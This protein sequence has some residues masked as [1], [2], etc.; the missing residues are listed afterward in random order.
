MKYRQ[1]DINLNIGVGKPRKLTYHI[2]EEPAVNTFNEELAKEYAKHYRLVDKKVLEVKPL[3]EILNDYMPK[4]TD[5]DFMN[6]DVE[7]MDLEVLESNDW[8]KYRPK[9]IL[10]EVLNISSIEDIIKHEITMFLRKKGYAL[11][12]KSFNTCFFKER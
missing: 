7:G 11:F 12:A 5:I 4:N 8:Y 10:V 3:S 9:I 6:I 2:F 1:K